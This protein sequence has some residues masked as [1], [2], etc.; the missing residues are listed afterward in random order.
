MSVTTWN[1]SPNYDL[2]GADSYWSCEDWILWHSLLKEKFGKKKANFIWD[3]AFAKSG[4]LSSNLDCRTF[5]SVFKAYVRDN[6]LKPYS[7]AGV[8]SPI[9]EAT[10]SVQDIFSQTLSGITSFLSSNNIKKILNIAS[11]GAV[12][13]GGVYIYKTFKK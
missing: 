6:G 5:N 13:I 3:Y 12:V 9:L 7:N 11:I 4:T 2:W 8:F 10:G 1:T